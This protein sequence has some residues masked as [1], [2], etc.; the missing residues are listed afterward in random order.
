MA[1]TNSGNENLRRLAEQKALAAGLDTQLPT[2][3]DFSALVQELR[4][5]QIELEM[6]NEELRASRNELE[7]TRD[8]YA[9]L[10][11]QS[12]LAY[13]TLD[14]SG[15]IRRANQT[16]ADLIG[17]EAAALAGLPFVS[18]LHADDEAVFLGRFSSIFRHPHG[19]QLDVRLN[20]TKRNCI[21]ARIHARQSQAGNSLLLALVDITSQKQAE[22]QIKALLDEKQ[23]LLRE[24][25]HRIKN[26]M[27]VINAFLSLQAGMCQASEAVEAL[28]EAQSRVMSMMIIYDKLY[29]SED[30]LH[31]SAHEYLTD[32]LEVIATQFSDKDICIETEVENLM[33]D[34][35]VL[36][37]LGIIINELLTNAFKYAF[38]NTQS[39]CIK[40]RVAKTAENQAI[41]EV[42]D[43]GIGLP[44]DA[45]AGG[46]GFGFILVDALVE[47]LGGKLASRSLSSCEGLLGGSCFSISFPMKKNGFN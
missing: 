45:V 41:C 44:A 16:F 28:T 11:N 7:Q 39:G 17:Q 31:I 15:I 36:F 22:D 34:S 23:I 25:H 8:L 35:S 12:P 20:T 9:Q 6:Q 4:V 37:P 26:N 29:R 46:N 33:L 24:V 21:I 32:L 14:A 40:V 2:G 18:L 27:N 43:T 3:T 30:F 38:P 19:K 5:H 1:T 10:Y 47:Q 13:L 42:S